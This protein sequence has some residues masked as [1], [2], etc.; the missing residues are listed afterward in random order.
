MTYR[1]AIFFLSKVTQRRKLETD[2]QYPGHNGGRG[3][4][5]H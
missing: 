4:H 5:R 1:S 3:R 2:P